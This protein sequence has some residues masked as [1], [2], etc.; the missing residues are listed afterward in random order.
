MQNGTQMTQ[1]TQINAARGRTLLICAN[2]RN[3]RHL[4]AILQFAIRL[5]PV[6]GY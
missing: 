2:L 6:V 4:R 1:M 3:L 5:H